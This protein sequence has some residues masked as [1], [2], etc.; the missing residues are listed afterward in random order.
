LY[1]QCQA[2][3]HFTQ[4]HIAGEIAHVVLVRKLK[5]KRRAKTEERHLT[6]LALMDRPRV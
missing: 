6:P 1:V 5:D 4:G 3:F 2:A